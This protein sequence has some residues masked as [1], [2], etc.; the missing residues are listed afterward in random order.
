MNTYDLI[1]ADTRGSKIIRHL[2][3][4]L[5]WFTF[6]VSG[7][8]ELRVMTIS[9]ALLVGL[10][11]VIFLFP[12]TIIFCYVVLYVLVP[13]LL[14]KKRFILFFIVILIFALLNGFANINICNYIINPLQPR[15]LFNNSP[16]HNIIT[17]SLNATYLF[18]LTCGT[19]VS[20]KLAKAWYFQ[21]SNIYELKNT[22]KEYE[23]NIDK[24]RSRN[25]ITQLL[26]RTIRKIQNFSNDPLFAKLQ[27][28]IEYSLNESGPALIS[29][30]KEI[31]AI[32]DYIEVNQ[33]LEFDLNI[34]VSIINKADP[35]ANVSRGI[36]INVI[37]AVLSQ[38]LKLDSKPSVLEIN[39]QVLKFY[40]ELSVKT[41][42]EAPEALLNPA[43]SLALA[44]N[45]NKLKTYYP[46]AHSL[47]LSVE[48][49]A[50][51]LCL[52]MD[53]DKVVKTATLLADV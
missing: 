50:L 36:L 46:K 5:F 23:R 11:N 53:L 41:F 29:T 48:G 20:I 18:F 3:F 44:L 13:K 4:W 40:L 17:G 10:E 25:F 24:V 28:L 38:A 9:H 33:R 37:E 21:E 52:K 26:E 7:A 19:S 45:E 30:E 39:I 8:M 49:G 35:K 22:L 43:L 6:R 42:T 47:K 27:P 2:C 31:E 16:L 51:I 1:Y 15:P 12:L 34:D 32:A 14:F